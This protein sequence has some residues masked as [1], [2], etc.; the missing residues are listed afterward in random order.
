[1]S[2]IFNNKPYCQQ[3]LE[4]HHI[5]LPG[6]NFTSKE[7]KLTWIEDNLDTPMRRDGESDKDTMKRFLGKNKRA[8]GIDCRCATCENKRDHKELEPPSFHDLMKAFK[9]VEEAQHIEAAMEIVNG[10]SL[11]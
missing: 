10:D 9:C 5:L 4:S 1:M 11:F 7:E 3:V 8:Q 2:D 6:R